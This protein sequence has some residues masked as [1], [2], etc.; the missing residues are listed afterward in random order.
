MPVKYR[1][2]T[3]LSL[4]FLVT[5]FVP[6]L[7]WGRLESVEVPLHFNYAGVPD[8][9]GSCGNL[10]VLPLVACVVCFLALYCIRKPQLINYPVKISK[11]NRQ[12]L[13]PLGIKFVQYINIGVMLLLSYISNSSLMIALGHWTKMPVGPLYFLL[14]LII[15]LTGIFWWNIR[16][17]GKRLE[18]DNIK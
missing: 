3:V 16:R 14:G 9:W 18:N 8:S 12:R 17:V 10:L 11:E 7:F 13:F 15:L 2:H 1:Y 4:L 5:S 6:L